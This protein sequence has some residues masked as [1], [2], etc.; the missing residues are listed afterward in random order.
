MRTTVLLPDSVRVGKYV[1]SQAHSTLYKIQ[2]T[3]MLD[4]HLT[5]LKAECLNFYIL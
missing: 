2:G 4:H 5:R 1:L 3:Q